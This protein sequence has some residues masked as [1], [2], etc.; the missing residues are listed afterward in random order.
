[1]AGVSVDTTNHMIYVTGNNV[2]LDGYD[3]S[4]NGGWGVV[5][6]GSNTKILDSSFVVG[7][8]SI[9]PILAAASSS[10]LTVAYCTIDGHN[11]GN[12]SG[13]IENRGS[14]ALTVQYSWLKNAGGDMIQMHNGGQAA[15]LVVEYNVIQNAGMAPGAH[16]DYT[17]FMDG[18]FTATIKYNTTTQNGGAT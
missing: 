13:L 12:I 7:A 5:V 14:G 8:N 17:E 3:F 1:M 16:G 10:N 11:D 2:T 18:P 15:N 6:Q 4:V 9:K